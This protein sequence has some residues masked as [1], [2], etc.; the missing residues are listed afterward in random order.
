LAI[1]DFLLASKSLCKKDER[2]KGKKKLTDLSI[3]LAAQPD[4]AVEFE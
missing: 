3:E 1:I 2:G 4:A